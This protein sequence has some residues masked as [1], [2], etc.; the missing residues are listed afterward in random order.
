MPSRETRR[1]PRQTDKKTDAR[2][3]KGAMAMQV[4]P[5]LRIHEVFHPTDSSPESEATLLHALRVSLAAEARLTL[6]RVSPGGDAPTDDFPDV[7][8]T[9][10][11]W[12]ARWAIGEPVPELRVQWHAA[13]GNDPVRSCLQSLKRSPAELIVV[14]T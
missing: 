8:G 2:Q 10:A 6:M 11:R 12:A 5:W 1:N 3:T 9:V 13:S 14:A 7:R 4:A